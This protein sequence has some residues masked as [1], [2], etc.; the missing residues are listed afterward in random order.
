VG[1]TG[2]ITTFSVKVCGLP[3]LLSKGTLSDLGLA[4]SDTGMGGV[5]KTGTGGTKVGAED[6]AA[7]STLLAPMALAVSWGSSFCSTAG[8]NAQ[9]K[10]KKARAAPPVYPFKGQ[11]LGENSMGP[12]QRLGLYGFAWIWL[13]PTLKSLAGDW[14]NKGNKARSSAFKWRHM[15][16][17]KLRTKRPSGMSSNWSV[18]RE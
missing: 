13:R 16:K 15:P 17:A 14:G 18:S 3:T 5:S 9:S 12:D 10:A 7:P 2:V 4:G 8:Q 11:R 1:I 6:T